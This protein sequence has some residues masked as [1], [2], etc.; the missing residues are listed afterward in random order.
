[1]YLNSANSKNNN[2]YYF[3]TNNTQLISIYE[4]QHLNYLDKMMTNENISSH[5]PYYTDGLIN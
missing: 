1:M 3:T 2:P 5:I 4:K